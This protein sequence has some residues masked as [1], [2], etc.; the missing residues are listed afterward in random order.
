MSKAALGA[1]LLML[2]LFTYL[3]GVRPGYAL[4]YSLC[5]LFVIAWAWPRL[6][7]RGLSFSRHLDPGTPTV[8]EPFEETF[9]VKK[10]GWVPAPWLEV[11]DLGQMPDYQPGRVFSA[12]AEKVT[13]RA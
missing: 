11:R 2:L 9:T 13:W 1:A 12:G 4:A 10:T 8:G 7:I 5:F 6:V 3:L